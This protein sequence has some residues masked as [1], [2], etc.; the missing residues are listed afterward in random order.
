MSPKIVDKEQKKN[1]IM[2]A[3]MR[4]FAA[5]GAAKAKMTDIANEAGIGKGTIYEYFPGKE[6]IFAAAFN[7]HFQNMENA[8]RATINSSKDPV[9]KLNQLIQHSLRMFLSDSGEFAEIMMD[10]WA[11]GIRNKDSKI[12][13]IIDLNQI[14][15]N[16][17]KYISEILTEG[18]QSGIFKELDTNAM[19]SVLIA[20]LDG[21]LLQWIMARDTFDPEK[22]TDTMLDG[23]LNG[24]IKP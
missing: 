19:S 23:F 4:V 21:L 7:Y 2:L 12:L 17:R 14:Y 5:K 18:I 20:A 8:T 22:A 9:S 6:D 13:K 10:F 11:E 16:Y 1:E 3:A 15:I 24:I